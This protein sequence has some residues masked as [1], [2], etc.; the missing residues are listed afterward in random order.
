MNAADNKIKVSYYD[1]SE[2]SVLPST[3]LSSLTPY[4]VDRVE[5]IDF[6][7]E[8][9]AE[10]ATS[11]RSEYIGAW[12]KGQLQFDNGES[13]KLCLSSDDGSKLYINDSLVI[14][15]DG[16]HSKETLC[17]ETINLSGEVLDVE[18]EYF[19]GGMCMHQYFED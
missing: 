19:D 17:Y 18:V 9:G 5:T 8:E 13:V 4:K 3:R 14:D 1:A 7:P 6:H 11:G 15:N 10:F 12:F 16:L 2:W